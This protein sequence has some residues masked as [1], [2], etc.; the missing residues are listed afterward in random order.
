MVTDRYDEMA[1]FYGQDLG[2]KVVR[3]WDRSNARG[4]RFDLG[5]VRLEL[6]DNQRERKP[7]SLGTPADRFH[8]VIEVDDIEAARQGLKI[9]APPVQTTSW[10]AELF[11]LH[12]PDGV[13]VTFLRWTGN[14]GEGS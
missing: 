14:A 10:G 6:I 11:E 9:K 1:R 13:R 4:L 2:F 3:Q 5:G 8:V 12:D 7:L